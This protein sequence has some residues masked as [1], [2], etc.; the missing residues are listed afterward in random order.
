[1]LGCSSIAHPRRTAVALSRIDAGGQNVAF[2]QWSATMAAE[3]TEC[4]CGCAAEVFGLLQAAGHQHVATHSG[5][6]HGRDVQRSVGGDRDGLPLRH[7]CSVQRHAHGSAGDAHACRRLETEGP[8]RLSC[9]RGRRR[10]RGLPSTLLPSRKDRSSI[11]PD[12]GTPTCQNPVRPGQS[13]TVVSIP[14]R[15]TSIAVIRRRSPSA[16]EWGRTR[17]RDC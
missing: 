17:C 6:G 15:T 16:P 8:D 1:M 11:G 3:R 4:E 14:G 5:T 12:G 2:T 9:I 10:P 7:W 13:W